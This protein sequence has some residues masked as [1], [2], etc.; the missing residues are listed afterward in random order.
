MT[1]YDALD[2]L[3]AF[4]DAY[5]AAEFIPEDDLARAYDALND[6]EAAL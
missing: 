1:P 3:R 2:F 4:L 5:A 6:I